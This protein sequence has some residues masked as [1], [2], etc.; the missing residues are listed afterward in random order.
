M[1]LYS[2]FILAFLIL[3]LV[4]PFGAQAQDHPPQFL[5]QKDGRLYLADATTG[6]SMALPGIVYRYPATFTW[7]PNSR[8][9]LELFHSQNGDMLRVYDI[10]HGEYRTDIDISGPPFDFDFAA[11]SPDSTRISYARNTNFGTGQLWLLDISTGEQTL[12]YQSLNVRGRETGVY[13]QWWA[14]LGN[15][16]LFEGFR[17]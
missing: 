14:P 8:Y 15:R 5:Y 9:L 4:A 11:W 16:L 3:L 12:L 6:E 10:D 13:E 17:E 1:P 2:K 7:S